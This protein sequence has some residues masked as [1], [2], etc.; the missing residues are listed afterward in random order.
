MRTCGGRRLPAVKTIKQKR[1]N[2][3]LKRETANA[4]I[5]ATSRVMSTAGTAMISELR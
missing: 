5:D 2:R 1:L 4:T 3:Q